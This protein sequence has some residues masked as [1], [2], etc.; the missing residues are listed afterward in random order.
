M[1]E[2]TFVAHLTQFVLPHGIAKAVDTDLPAACQ[3]AYEDMM[4]HGCR[5]E[6]EVLSNGV[7][8]VAIS[9]KEAGVDVDISLTPNG[10][11]VHAGMVAMLERAMWRENHSVDVNEK[12][13]GAK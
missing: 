9:D 8:S 10:P 2:P 11:E 6:C 4:K 13:G 5:F 1:S 7:V 12:V 3:P